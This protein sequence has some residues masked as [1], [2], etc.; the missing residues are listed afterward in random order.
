MTTF[1]IDVGDKLRALFRDGKLYPAE[2][3]QVSDVKKYAD[4]PFKVH[5]TGYDSNE[6]VWVG[7]EGL[8]S[9]KG[10][11]TPSPGLEI[12]AK[13]N[14]N[15]KGWNYP[16]EIVR[17]LIH[18]PRK[19]VVQ[20]R[21]DESEGEYWLPHDQIELLKK[22][23]PPQAKT[24]VSVPDLSGLLGKSVSAEVDGEYYAAEVVVVSV[25]KARAKA[26]IKVHFKDYGVEMDMWLP[27]EMVWVKK[28][29]KAKSSTKA[30]PNA[31]KTADLSAI[32]RGMQL[33]AE[34]EGTWFLAEVVSVSQKNGGSVKVHFSGHDA[35]EDMWLPLD[36]IRSK[37]IPKATL[38]T[39]EPS[40]AAPAGLAVGDLSLGM[41]LM[42]CGPD[43]IF[44]PAEV[45]S[46]STLKARAKTPVKVHFIDYG[47]EY[48]L[49]MPMDK[50]QLKQRK[51]EKASGKGKGKTKTKS[52]GKQKSNNKNNGDY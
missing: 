39:V 18:R 19:A 4:S 28:E 42:A 43:N 50:L 13:V 15:Y 16:A 37:K 7:L 8:R 31:S 10:A 27:P 26:P 29:S 20:V 32:S 46:V 41:E 2:V 49:W 21:F 33:Q 17:V 9:K 25:S 24:D 36:K 1:G 22:K 30:K 47:P 23:E 40:N 44:Y 45:V 3:V 6:D 51:K 14:A 34:Y 48:D 52:R 12:G 38:P 5:F 11:V 35:S